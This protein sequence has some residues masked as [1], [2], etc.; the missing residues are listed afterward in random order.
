MEDWPADHNNMH[1][2]TN[3][4]SMHSQTWSLAE[5]PLDGSRIKG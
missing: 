5:L 2:P 1:R 4:G 3:A